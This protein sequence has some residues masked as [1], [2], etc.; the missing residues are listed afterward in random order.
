MQMVIAGYGVF[1]GPTQ[2]VLTVR[3]QAVLTWRALEPGRTRIE[4]FAFRISAWWS[5][6]RLVQS[7]RYRTPVACSSPPDQL[8]DNESFPRQRGTRR[9]RRGRNKKRGTVNRD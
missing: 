3:F 6:R 1:D 9:E 2:T 8:R 5:G 4:R 7:E